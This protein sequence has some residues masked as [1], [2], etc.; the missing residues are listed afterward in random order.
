MSQVG[1]VHDD[2]PKRAVA[3]YDDEGLFDDL[4]LD[5]THPINHFNF[6]A[7]LMRYPIGE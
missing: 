3:K 6:K 7:T 5:I 1:P 4:D 2:R